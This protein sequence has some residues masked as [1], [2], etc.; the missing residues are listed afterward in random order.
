[1]EIKAPD[2]YYD[3]KAKYTKGESDYVV[4]AELGDE[5]TR[6]CQALGRKTYDALACRGMGRVDIRLTPDGAPFVLELNSIPGF[7]ETSLLPMAAQAAG[8][9]FS[10]LC[11]GIMQTA[12]L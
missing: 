5:E 7:T 8:I 11:D 2:G 3:Y 4:P 10:A 1:V 12:S 6:A 9:E